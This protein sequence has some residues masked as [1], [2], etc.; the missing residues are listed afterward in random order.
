MRKQIFGKKLSRERGSREALFVSLVESL[1]INK[2]I[3]TTK[4]KAK[5]VIPFV[6]KLALL[7]IKGDFSDKKNVLKKLRGNKKSFVLLGKEMARFDKV[8]KAGFVRIVPLP[9]R[10]GDKAEMV[11]LEW[12]Y[13]DISTQK[14]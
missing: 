3:R 4:A 10:K 8:K 13:E 5:A 11:R 14:K 9:S 7:S 1:I 2:R 6:E 12:T